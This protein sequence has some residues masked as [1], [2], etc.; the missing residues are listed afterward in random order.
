[1]MDTNDIPSGLGELRDR[2]GKLEAGF[3]GLKSDVAENTELTKKVA[4]DTS[5]LVEFAR[6]AAWVGK[7]AKPI[8]YLAAIGASVAAVWAAFKTGVGMR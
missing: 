5:D 3:A 1:M 2:V 4:S 8:S 7:V 6:A